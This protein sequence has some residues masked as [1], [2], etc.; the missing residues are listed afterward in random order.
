[1]LKPQGDYRPYQV[2]SRAENTAQEVE[3]N[4]SQALSNQSIFNPF[5]QDPR[6]SKVNYLR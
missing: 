5:F 6:A 2:F 4:R 1:M 3:M